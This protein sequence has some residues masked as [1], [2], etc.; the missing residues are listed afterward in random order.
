MNSAYSDDQL[1]VI[2]LSSDVDHTTNLNVVTFFTF[3]II[4]LRVE[5]Q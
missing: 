4:F 1:M 5:D 2:P 3:L